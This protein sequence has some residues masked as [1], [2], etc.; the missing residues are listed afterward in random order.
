[1]LR[2]D[3][4]KSLEAL[5]QK[6]Q[7]FTDA[8]SLLTYEVDAGVDRGM[9]EGVALPHS[10][11]DVARIV[12]WAA[13][14]HVPLVGRGAGTGLSGGAVAEHGGLIIEFSRMN[15]V[16]ELDVYGRAVLVEPGIINLRV[17]ERVRAH[18]LYFP[19]DPASQRASTIGGNV[20]ENSGGPHC[21]KYG[22]MT[23]YVTGMQVVLAD[24]SIAQVGGR[25]LDY[26]EYDFCGLLTGSEGMLVLMTAINVR[27]VRNP[28]GIKTMLAVFDSVEQAGVA[29]SAVIAAGLVPATMEMMDQKIIR[30]VEAWLHAGLPTEAAA[31][32]IIEVDGYPESLDKQIEEVAAIL[33]SHGGHDLRV[34][35]SEEERS[36]I[37][38]AR[39]SAAGAIARLAPAHYTVDI[40]VPRSRL[41]E[42]LLEVNEICE[43]YNLPV[44]YVFHAGDGN[45]HPLILIPDAQDEEYMQ[46][47]RSA[48][49]ETVAVAIRKDGSL[50]GEH[51]VGIEKRAFMSLMFNETELSAMLD[52]KS[53]FD[54]HNLLNPGKIFPASSLATGDRHIAL[55]NILPTNVDG[56]AGK[57]TINFAPT[58][59][60]EA[61]QALAACAHAGQRVYITGKQDAGKVDAIK[62]VPTEVTLATNA[63][64]GIKTYAPDDL[65]ITVGAGT[66][67]AEMQAFLAEHNRF[68]PVASPW[69]GTT[70]GGLLATNLNA[71]LRMRYGAIR[72]LVLSLT[73][74]LADGRVIRVGRPVMK[75]VAGFD[76]VKLFV[77]SHGTLGLITEV[78]LKYAAQPRARRT[79]F[80]PIDDLRHGLLRARQLLRSSLVASAVALCNRCDTVDIPH[81]PYTLIYTAEGIEEDVQAELAQARAILR[82]TGAPEPI[83]IAG[84]SGTDVWV[85]LLK[86]A[87]DAVQVRVGLPL[88]DVPVYAQ[89]HASILNTGAFFADFGNGF[90]YATLPASAS[91]TILTAVEQLRRSALEAGGYAIVTQAPDDW[92]GTLDRWGYTPEMLDMMRRLK[93]RWDPQGIMNPGEFIV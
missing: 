58:S 62:R 18:G 40:T 34:A 91:E 14:H 37:W 52:I 28:P 49:H 83:E 38:L 43:R 6:G 76:L 51:G 33:R 13:Q 87:G 20:S 72:D 1:M 84:V 7:V 21:F 66:L 88:R 36:Q 42:T 39:K 68:V 26:P 60:G 27:L 67:L 73:V 41:A 61:A 56:T 71:P 46:R 23:N 30:I 80:L 53:I 59:T 93:A 3:A 9:P 47:V 22:V 77:G 64:R 86:Q 90:L 81:S 25:A 24:G 65:Y 55:T 11:E 15:R 57:D 75:N 45:L 29:T 2:Q 69:P 78:T 32:L 74:A 92:Q 48:G 5:L 10:A 8:A 50:S 44:G 17:D 89:D 79:L 4:L 70:I 63:L 85:N 31:M 19:P 82:Q 35:A 16:L 54:P 12:R